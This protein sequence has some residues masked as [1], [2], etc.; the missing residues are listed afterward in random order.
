MNKNVKISNSLIKKKVIDI[1]YIQWS[2]SYGSWIYSM[3]MVVW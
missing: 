1:T 3:V 2:W